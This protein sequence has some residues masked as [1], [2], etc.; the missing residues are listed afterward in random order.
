M[1]LGNEMWTDLMKLFPWRGVGFH[2]Y[3]L[4]LLL[5]NNFVSLYTFCVLWHFF[6]FIWQLPCWWF[7]ACVLHRITETL[8]HKFPALLSHMYFHI[9]VFMLM[10]CRVVYKLLASKSE[11]IRVQT[12]KVLGYFLKH[13]GHKWVNLRFV[14]IVS[15]LWK[16]H[17]SRRYSTFMFWW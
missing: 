12:L 10:F 15:G 16:L 17:G 4:I 9:G 7:S 13:L 11:S 5:G 1:C 3:C 8:Y 14:H 6:H 2:T